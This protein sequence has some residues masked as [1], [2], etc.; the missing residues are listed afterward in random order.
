MGLLLPKRCKGCKGKGT[1]ANPAIEEWCCT[2]AG[3]NETTKDEEE[4]GKDEPE[5]VFNLPGAGR[6]TRC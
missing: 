2:R 6:Q 5:D 4:V 3:E 1:A